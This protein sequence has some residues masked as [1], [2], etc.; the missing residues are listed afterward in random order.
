MLQYSPLALL[1]MQALAS[2]A[3]ADEQA[4]E[5]QHQDTE[6]IV[7]SASPLNRTELNSAQPISVL[8]GDE[9]REKQAHTLGETLAKEPGIN[10][11]HFARVASSP[12]IRGLD[13]PRV[14][15]MQNGLDTA[16]VS[17]GSPDHAVTTETSVAQQVEIMRGP[18]TLLYGS[19]AI[20][21]VV[22][23]VDERIAQ[24]FV[25]GTRGF[26]GGN[27]ASVDNL[28]DINAGIT[29]DVGSSVWHLDGFTRQSD[30]YSVPT[31]T[32]E[33]GEQ[34]DT[35][36]N[37][38]VDA[39][40]GTLGVSYL[41][42]NGYA[43]IS[44]GRLEQSYGIPGHSH[45]DHEGESEQEHAEHEE[46]TEAQPYADLE[47]DRFQLHAGVMD[48]IAGIEKLEVRYAYTDY[49]HQEI[50][51]DITATSFT[52][53]QHELRL[54]ANHHLS[55][56]W[57]G[58]IG[59]HGFSQQQTT[60]GEEAYAPPSETDRHGFFWLAETQGADLNW[61]TGIRY[62]KVS[63]EAPSLMT[64]QN[65]YNF[66]PF[67]ASFG[68]SYQWHPEIRFNANVSHAQRAPTAN[69]LFANGAHLATQTYELGLGYELHQEGEHSYAVEPS[70]QHIALETSTGLD[71]GA[72]FESNGH[73]LNI[74]FYANH[75]DN[76]IFESFTGVNSADLE[77]HDEHDE[78]DEHEQHDEHDHDEGL[79]VVEYTQRDVVLFGY[80]INGLWQLDEQWRLQAFSDYT[81]AYTRDDQSNLPRIPSQRIGADLTYNQGNWETQVGYIWH[82]R[83]NRTAANE[84]ATPSYGLVNAQF[85]WFPQAFAQQ[86]LSIYLK[87]ENLTDKLAYVHTSYLKMNAPVAGRNFSIGLRGEF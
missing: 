46:E 71:L 44:Y 77:S 18:A 2:P 56:N 22:N 87:A 57:Y 66:E 43:G 74:N 23:V 37:S 68:A 86:N 25:G 79:T 76:Y 48:P 61:Q 82:S 34:V 78:H 75:I 8:S 51:A 16:D 70:Q 49:Q 39:A 13:G 9:L 15:I 11:T 59:Y 28:R 6:V 7:I 54:T 26:F 42:D 20:G 73:H 21:G 14:K 5:H 40:G 38:F 52:N 62:E 60:F 55:G 69:E 53:K 1:V 30:D 58:A 64:G 84:S 81:R 19:G 3:N 10:A 12:I 33:E 72:H 83:Q 45:D 29:T 35:I 80:E 17:R 32:N 65:S 31:F 50:E 85:N 47:Q 24:D 63:A 67:S 27:L 36:N 4:Q 41:F